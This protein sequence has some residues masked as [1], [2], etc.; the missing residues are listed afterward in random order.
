MTWDRR[1]ICVM[2]AQK[3]RIINDGNPLGIEKS[4]GFLQARD[5]WGFKLV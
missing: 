3:L 5:L 2:G 4:F 1:S